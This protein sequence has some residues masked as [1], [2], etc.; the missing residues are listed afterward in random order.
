[1]TQPI[2]AYI[3]TD[4]QHRDEPD[5]CVSIDPRGQWWVTQTPHDGCAIAVAM[6]NMRSIHG[7]IEAIIWSLR[8]GLRYDTGIA[9]QIGAHGT[10]VRLYGA[11]PNSNCWETFWEHNV[12]PRRTPTGVAVLALLELM[13]KPETRRGAWVTA[14]N[15]VLSWRDIDVDRGR[16]EDPRLGVPM[17]N[18]VWELEIEEIAFGRGRINIT[19]GTFISEFW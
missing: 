9:P 1:M 6:S 15:L 13:D 4:G 17:G 7:L 3:R 2:V 10:I 12:N 8:T 19:D 11:H 14:R 16:L 18:G 5:Y